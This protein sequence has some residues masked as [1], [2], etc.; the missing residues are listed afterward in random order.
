MHCKCVKVLNDV[1]QYALNRKQCMDRSVEFFMMTSSKETFSA[2]LVFFAGIHRSPV[3]FPHK[4]QWREALMFSLICVWING[5]VN[6]GEAGDL[7]RYRAHY[8]VTVMFMNS[9]DCHCGG[10]FFQC[11]ATRKINTKVTLELVATVHYYDVIMG[12]M[13]SQITRLTIVY[14]KV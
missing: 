1:V 13:A 7:R 9:R 14:S 2:L 6:N 8:D 5:W 12:A 3:N 11:S 10:Y 4:C